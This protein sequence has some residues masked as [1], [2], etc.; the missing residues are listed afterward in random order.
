MSLLHA[1]SFDW[2][3]DAADSAL[4]ADRYDLRD[5]NVVI[6][7]SGAN[8][9][10]ING[11]TATSP[12][13][14][15]RRVLSTPDDTVICGFHLNPLALSARTICRFLDATNDIHGVLAITA[16]GKIEAYKDDAITLIAASDAGVLVAGDESW[17]EC[18]YVVSADATEGFIVVGVDDVSVIRIR[19]DTKG[20]AGTTV[21]GIELVLDADTVCDNWVIKNSLGTSHNDYGG[22]SFIELTSPHDAAYEYEGGSSAADYEWFTS[23]G[24]HVENNREINEVPTTSPDDDTSFVH[25]SG[26]ASGEQDTHRCTDPLLEDTL[27]ISI[28]LTAISLLYRARREAAGSETFV[29]RQWYA[30]ADIQ[31]DADTLTVDST[32]YFYLTSILEEAAGGVAWDVGKYGGSEFGYKEP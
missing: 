9:T 1:D 16:D 5:A 4:L 11:V 12:D 3:P 23:G 31:E 27:G 13:Q 15:L 29:A 20:A 7:D 22:E 14:R 10:W 28:P 8:V 30:A 18:K 17:I 6:D 24:D 2:I 32:S 21:A 26:V 19:A 25:N